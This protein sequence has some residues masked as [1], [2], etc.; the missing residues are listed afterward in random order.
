M[1]YLSVPVIA[2]LTAGSLLSPIQSLFRTLFVCFIYV[3]GVREYRLSSILDEPL[4]KHIHWKLVESAWF[5]I[6]SISH[7]KLGGGQGFFFHWSR[8]PIT[9][10]I[11]WGWG[12]VVR[13]V[14]GSSSRP[15]VVISIIMW[16]PKYSLKILLRDKKVTKKEPPMQNVSV[17]HS[18]NNQ[19][20]EFIVLKVRAPTVEYSSQTSIVDEIV[21]SYKYALEHYSVIPNYAALIIGPPGT[22]KSCCGRLI[23]SRLKCNL[24]LGFNPTT[25]GHRLL[26][27]IDRFKPNRDK[28]LVILIEEFDKILNSIMDGSFNS[29]GID[30]KIPVSNKSELS[31]MLDLINDT[32]YLICILT[33]NALSEFWKKDDLLFAT[34]P[35][36]VGSIHLLPRCGKEEAIELVAKYV[37]RH[38]LEDKINEDDVNALVNALN[39][40]DALPT[41]AQIEQAFKNCIGDFQKVEEYLLKNTKP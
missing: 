22:G 21:K 9:R 40:S 36:R 16:G 29:V 24:V 1:S 14:G 10:K 18:S 3:L 6:T 5:P 39:D 26:Y 2:G 11:N 7:G 30:T 37:E 32:P 15:N 34:R 20:L 25:P 27:I 31:E 23:A 17:C 4:V 38:A 12:W 13:R 28:P 41:I 35:G 19:K 8:D 33:S